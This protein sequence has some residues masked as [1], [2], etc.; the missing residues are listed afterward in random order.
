VGKEWV[1]GQVGE[2]VCEGVESKKLFTARGSR[3]GKGW[4]KGGLTASFQYIYFPCQNF[5]L[6]ITEEGENLV[7]FFG[8][9]FFVI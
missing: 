2:G 9:L 3:A 5:T 8:F 6:K 7:I 1:K 4:V